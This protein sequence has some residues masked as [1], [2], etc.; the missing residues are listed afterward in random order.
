MKK[1]LVGLMFVAAAWGQITTIPSNAGNGSGWNAPTAY[2]SLEACAS[3][4]FT[5]LLDSFYDF[6]YCDGASYSFYRDGQRWDIV[7][8]TGWSLYNEETGDSLTFAGGG[9]DFV[10]VRTAVGEHTVAWRAAPTA[11]YTID[12]LIF[13]DF[14]G[15][16]AGA[17][18]GG[19]DAN[20]GVYFS[21]ATEELLYF[22]FGSFADGAGVQL[23]NWSSAAGSLTSTI[24]AE[25]A[26]G[27]GALWDIIYDNPIRIR[28]EDDTTDLKFYRFI[29]NTPFQFGA[30]LTRTTHLS[31]GPTRYGFG[32]YKGDG[33]I[34]LQVIGINEE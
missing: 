13:H 29:G 19:R 15:E 25:T 33:T 5:P 8:T 18:G 31:S 9:A 1:L 4:R 34:R 26:N 2:A 12:F 22:G 20:F 11:P 30:S 17:T 16:N 27:G 21:D 32:G 10:A 6:A 23:Q 3:A 14:S 7:P 28:I 24:T